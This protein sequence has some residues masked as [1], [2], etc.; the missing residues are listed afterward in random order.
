LKL[1]EI[2]SR[3]LEYTVHEWPSGILY[4]NDGA[5]IGQCDEILES[6]KELIRLDNSETIIQL[7]NNVKKKTIQYRI[8]LANQAF[9]HRPI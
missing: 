3:F 5:S 8:K 9:P 7:A 4:G 1:I 6:I 2:I